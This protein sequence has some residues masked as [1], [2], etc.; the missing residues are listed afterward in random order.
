MNYLLTNSK[1][2]SLVSPS[3]TGT[4]RTCSVYPFFAMLTRYTPGARF[5]IRKPPLSALFCTIRR[6]TKKALQP[7]AIHPL[8]FISKINL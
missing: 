6:I 7:R 2:T 5:L 1:F 8:L 4:E 3:E